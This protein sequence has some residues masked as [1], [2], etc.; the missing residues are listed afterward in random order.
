M[1][2]TKSAKVNLNNTNCNNVA[3]LM[4]HLKFHSWN[5]II[6]NFVWKIGIIIQLISASWIYLIKVS[7]QRRERVPATWLVIRHTKSKQIIFRKQIDA[8][9]LNIFH[10]VA[11]WGLA[12]PACTYSATLM[13]AKILKH[14]RH[15]FGKIFWKIGK[16]SGQSSKLD[17]ICVSPAHWLW[18]LTDTFMKQVLQHRILK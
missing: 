7:P 6:S 12:G 16:I 4:C 10:W 5:T 8:E 14:Y 3:C 9:L 18:S 1:Q 17:Q 11:K 2:R 13:R 15:F